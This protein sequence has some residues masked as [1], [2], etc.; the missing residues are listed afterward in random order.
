MGKKYFVFDYYHTKGRSLWV[1]CCLEKRLL[2]ETKQF[3]LLDPE[4]VLPKERQERALAFL[5][6]MHVKEVW[7]YKEKNAMD[8]SLFGKKLHYSEGEGGEFFHYDFI[9]PKLHRDTFRSRGIELREFRGTDLP[10][11]PY[12]LLTE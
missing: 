11:D 2:K 8:D 5:K 1:V 9:N 6:R 4:D 10:E 7:S 12:R 3:T